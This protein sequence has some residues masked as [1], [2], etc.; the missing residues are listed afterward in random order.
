MNILQ[1]S[2]LELADLRLIA[3]VCQHGT[4]S[5]AAQTLHLSQ[6][7][8]S[9]RLAGLEDR[10][11]IRLFD[12]LGRNMR[13]TPAVLEFDRSGREI[14]AAVR[15]A[16]EE[17]RSKVKNEKLILRLATQCYTCYKWLPRVLRRYEEQCPL[18]KIHI[19]LTATADPIRALLEERVD[20][21]VIDQFAPK[22]RRLQ[23]RRLFSDEVVAVV[24]PS[25][26]WAAR[27]SIAAADFRSERLIAHN[28][29]PDHNI[30]LKRILRP[31]NVMPADTYEIPL[32]EAI[33]ELVKAGF[34]VAALARWV[35]A[36]DLKEG[37]VRCIPIGKHGFARHWSIATLRKV[38]RLAHV[39]QFAD[40]ISDE[41]Q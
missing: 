8:L 3:A 31:S 41:L 27:R 37:S 28:C 39:K 21:V 30:V 16:E 4:L 12:R 29:S 15:K 32:T 1:A 5:R 11:G 18:C 26:P 38:S 7:A 34:G 17:V 25:H 19:D 33:L 36:T 2:S 35:V 13:P 24:A 20:V 6:S 10:L 22:D 9:H 23:I 40:L 14:L